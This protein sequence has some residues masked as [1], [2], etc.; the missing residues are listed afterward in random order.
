MINE[1]PGKENNGS[2]DVKK[3]FLFLR[4]LINQ[5]DT[6]LFSINLLFTKICVRSMENFDRYCRFVYK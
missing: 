4:K 6:I 5:T 3:Y 1:E 2:F